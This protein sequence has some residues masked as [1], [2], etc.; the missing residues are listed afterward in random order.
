MTDTKNKYCCLD[1][2][3]FYEMCMN[4]YNAYFTDPD[5]EA[6]M[7][8]YFENWHNEP[9]VSSATICEC[10]SEAAGGTTH[11]HWCPKGIK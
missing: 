1:K 8:E 4:C 7:F 9:K 6:A 5:F 2:T 11:S 10:G 3:N